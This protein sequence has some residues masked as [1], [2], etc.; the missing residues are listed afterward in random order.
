LEGGDA[1]GGEVM[2][3]EIEGGLGKR[4]FGEVDEEAV[5]AEDGEK[6]LEVGDVLIKGR[7][8]DKDVVQV[9]ESEREAFEEVVH[10]A[11]EGL[12]GVAEA[13]GHD[14]V[15]VEAKGGDD[16]SLGNVRRVNGDLVIAFDQV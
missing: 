7:T 13:K 16:C 5:V 2:T 1:G 8:G 12:G 9:D 6:F 10:E 14:K 3:E 15:F 4:A 11:L